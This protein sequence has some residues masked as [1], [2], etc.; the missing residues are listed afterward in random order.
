MEQSAK[1]I[2]KEDKMVRLF[3]KNDLKETQ[4]ILSR[5]ARKRQISKLLCRR[6]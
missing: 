6:R 3:K 1:Y 2:I 4:T 5:S